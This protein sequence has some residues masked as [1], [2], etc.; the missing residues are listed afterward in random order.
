MEVKSRHHL[1][2]DEI[3][4]IRDAVREGLGVEI[5]GDTFEG[6]E[7]TDSDERVVLETLAGL[8]T[9][10]AVAGFAEVLELLVPPVVPVAVLVVLPRVRPLQVRPARDTGDLRPAAAVPAAPHTPARSCPRT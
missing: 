8:V 1:R 5:E 7:F 4:E 9:E 2:G 3:D 6:V 10:V